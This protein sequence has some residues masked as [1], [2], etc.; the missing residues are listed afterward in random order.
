MKKKL[1][2]TQVSHTPFQIEISEYFTWQSTYMGLPFLS[3]DMFFVKSIL[4]SKN[5]ST[6]KLLQFHLSA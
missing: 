3:D 4:F 2:S 6:Q 1:Y 5:F